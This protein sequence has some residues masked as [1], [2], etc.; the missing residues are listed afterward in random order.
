M[1]K[2]RI[3][4]EENNTLETTLFNKSNQINKSKKENQ[5]LK[6]KINYLNNSKISLN[7]SLEM[8]EV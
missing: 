3:L 1:K 8:F 5:M 4:F 2:C 6:L 7:I